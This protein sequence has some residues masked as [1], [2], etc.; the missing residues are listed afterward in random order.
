MHSHNIL[1]WIGQVYFAGFVLVNNT[2]D[3]G[4]DIFSTKNNVE[5]KENEKTTFNYLHLS[6]SPRYTTSEFTKKHI[7][8]Y[9]KIC[10]FVSFGISLAVFACLTKK[11]RNHNF[12]YGCIIIG[13]K[14][15]IYSLFFRWKIHGYTQANMRVC[16]FHQN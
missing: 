14:R 3:L 10:L 8:L 7:H 13:S 6:L 11:I 12:I 4:S 16:V 15:I 9:I 5:V 2:L 1:F